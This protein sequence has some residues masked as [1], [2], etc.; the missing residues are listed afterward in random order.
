[1]A[2]APEMPQDLYS[3]YNNDINKRI[4]E[5]LR[6]ADPNVRIG[7]VLAID[8]LIDADT[9]EEGAVKI[10]RFANY[11]RSVVLTS[12]TDVLRAACE[13]M[14]K[15]TVDSGLA[16]DLVEFDVKR[17]L[18]WLQSDRQEVRRLAAVLNIKSIATHSPTLLY[19][20]I[21]PIIDNIWVALRDPKVVIRIDAAKCLQ[22][23]LNIIF[24]RDTKQNHPWFMRVLEEAQ[25]GFRI[26]TIEAVHGSLMVYRD[27]LESAGMFMQSRYG[28]VCDTIL[29]Y[30]DSKDQLIRRT[31][32][33]I[34]PDLA[35]YDPSQFTERYLVD[36]MS[37]LLSQLKKERE[38]SLIF[39][40]IG[41]VGGFVKSNMS[42]YLEPVLEAVREGL[43]TKGYALII[44]IFII[45]LLE[46]K[47]KKKEKELTK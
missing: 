11:L 8:H 12:D 21:G 28:E 1:M 27:L 2:V 16:K 41:R 46:K 3:R 22:E 13:T 25:N 30:K 14:G 37:Y 15:L 7:A 9:G 24:Q 10:T 38:R 42:V 19:S 39:E 32:I 36:S 26:G 18:E 34:V 45:F 4:F 29:R 33:L 43:Q 31:V 47:K 20:Y 6:S 23:C 35:K 17:S 40:A 5:L 44:F